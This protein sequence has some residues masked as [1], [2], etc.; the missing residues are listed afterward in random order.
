VKKVDRIPVLYGLVW[1]ALQG[2]NMGKELI[3]ALQFR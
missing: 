3:G 2:G 1:F